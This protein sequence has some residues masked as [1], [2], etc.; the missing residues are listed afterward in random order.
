MMNMHRR[1]FS[2]YPLYW[3]Q[4]SHLSVN[5]YL[6]KD[7]KKT[8]QKNKT[9]TKTKTETKIKNQKNV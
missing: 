5:I 8:K 6:F 4:L 3:E 2:I 1:S 9:K 7:S